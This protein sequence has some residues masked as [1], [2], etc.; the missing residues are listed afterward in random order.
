MTKEDIIKTAFKVWGRD[1]YR[2]M[3][4]SD[5]AQELGVSKAALYRH[6]KD[7]D[8]LLDAMNTAYFD[9]CTGFIRAGYDRALSAGDWVE[10]ILIMMRTLSEYY[11]RN[12]EAFVYS[13]VKASNSQNKNSMNNEMLRRGIDFSRLV[14]GGQRPDFYPSKTQLIMVT[15]IFCLSQF[16][17]H[18]KKGGEAL[19]EDEVT[20]AISQIERRMTRGLELD[21][22]KVAA[23]DFRRLEQQAAEP[24]H[25]D[26]ENNALLRAVAEAV[27]EAG[28]WNASME[29]VAK[30]SGLSKSGL[31]AHFKSKQD[32]LEQLFITEFTRIV[33]FAKAQIGTSEIPEEQLYLGIISII[34]YLR[35]R[36]EILVSMDWVKSSLFKLGKEMPIRLYGIIKDIKLEVIQNND[37]HFLV[38]IAQWIFFLILNTL[39]WWSSN[40]DGPPSYPGESKDWAKNAMEVPNESF[41]ILFRYIALGLEGLNT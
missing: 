37:L 40:K 15:N 10:S 2:T 18:G 9:D 38:W 31:Y 24:S 14:L 6:F 39:A 25:N 12:K 23:L 33:D 4:L 5:I 16:H 21:S 1:L 28:P 35:S 11:I 29:M 30:R 13:L 34:D 26:T 36:P 20:G 17:L 19:T 32:M 22:R 8:A 27:A 7:K 3:S 41:R